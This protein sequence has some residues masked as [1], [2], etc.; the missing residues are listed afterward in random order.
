[1]TGRPYVVYDV[2]TNEA[3]AGNPLAV[4]LDAAGLDTAAMQ[5]IALEFNLSETVF[6]SPPRAPAHAAAI[7]IF[8]PHYEMPFAGHPTV[9]TAIALAERA[10]PA[11]GEQAAL[12]VLEEKIGDVRCAVTRKAGQAAFAEFDLPQLSSR[13]DFTPDDAAIA[14]ALGVGLDDI[15][16]DAH[17]PC[18]WSAGVPY[19]AVP[20]KNLDV[21]ARLRFDASAW[22]DLAPLRDNGAPAS[23]YVYCRETRDEASSFHARMFVP[24]PPS[25]E[26]PA[27]G[28]AAAAFSGAILH[29]DRL[30]DGRHVCWIEQ[31]VEMGRPSRIRLELQVAAGKIEAARIGGEAVRVAQGTLDM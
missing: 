31:G 22:L 3:L 16:F 21:M 5:K 17:R 18:L 19:L 2:F 15:G 1:M 23:A 11:D 14:A 28:S 13:V 29:F 27:T 4:I 8:T 30:A 6:V 9:G 25:Y 24:G 10:G 26:D 20:V 7:R 12:L